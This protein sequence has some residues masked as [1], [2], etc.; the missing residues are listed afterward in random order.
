MEL[1]M[2]YSPSDLI[3]LFNGGDGGGNPQVLEKGIKLFTKFVSDD[4]EGCIESAIENNV[5][6]W[7]YFEDQDNSEEYSYEIQDLW[8]T[9][10]I[11][12]G[13]KLEVA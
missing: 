11:K 3:T 9:F 13:E 2:T 6:I 10:L 12:E 7:D 5:M 1:Q 4:Q 8:T